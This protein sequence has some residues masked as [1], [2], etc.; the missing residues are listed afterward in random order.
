[1]VVDSDESRCQ[2]AVV[3]DRTKP[4]GGVWARMGENE[5]GQREREGQTEGSGKRRGE[6]ERRGYTEEGDKEIDDGI[7]C[8]SHTSEGS[9]C[10]IGIGIV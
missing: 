1:M 4:S 3:D 7:G 9:V 10:C 2:V 6:R 8:G 5:W